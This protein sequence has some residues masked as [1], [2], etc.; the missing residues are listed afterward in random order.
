MSNPPPDSPTTT[1]LALNEDQPTERRLTERIWFKPAIGFFLLLMGLVLDDIVGCLGGVGCNVPAFSIVGTVLA[2]A[3]LVTGFATLVG[4]SLIGWFADEPGRTRRI[5]A[6]VAVVLGGLVLITID[7][8]LWR[9]AGAALVVIGVY[10]PTV[11]AAGSDAPHAIGRTSLFALAAVA[12]ALSMPAFYTH[13][14]VGVL[15][16]LGTGKIAAEVDQSAEQ[17]DVV[18]KVKFDPDLF[19]RE[20]LSQLGVFSGRDRADP[21]ILRLRAV[22]RDN[23]RQI[24]NLF[25]VES[26]TPL[27]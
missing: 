27:G 21:S 14:D 2:V 3:A 17:V 23:V 13:V 19:H 12:F 25:W 10:F 8:S 5:V 1:E 11:S 18:V 7:H 15:P 26:I 16:A 22:S 4:R 20:V 24:A 9:I 6:I